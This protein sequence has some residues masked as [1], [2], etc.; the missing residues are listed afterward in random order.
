[1]GRYWQLSASCKRRRRRRERE[2][3]SCKFEASGEIGG[4]VSDG[5]DR[6]GSQHHDFPRRGLSIPKE[7]R[8]SER[9]LVE[10]S[11][12]LVFDLVLVS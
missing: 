10:D 12:K 7:E 3:G 8:G 11:S 2:E 1:M 4:L 9:R 6:Y 5:I